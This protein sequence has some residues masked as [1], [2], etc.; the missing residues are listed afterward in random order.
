MNKLDFIQENENQK[1]LL[2]LE[3]QMDHV[4]PVRKLDL[5]LINKKKII[6]LLEDFAV[7]PDQSVKTKESEKID[8]YLD[9]TG[10]LKS[11]GI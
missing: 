10:E 9:I 2:E 7:L 1:I 11:C 4:I 6:C 3:I 8:K 5:V